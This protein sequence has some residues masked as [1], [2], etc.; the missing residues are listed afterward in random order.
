MNYSIEQANSSANCTSLHKISS[1]ISKAMFIITIIT[2]IITIIGILLNV[3]NAIVLLFKKSKLNESPYTYLTSLAFSDIAILANH[4]LNYFIRITNLFTK[5]FMY[6]FTLYY[7]I[8]FTNVALNCSMYFT[9]AVTVERFI[10]VHSPFKAVLI[11]RRSIARKVCLI[12][13]LF[14][15]IK[16]AYLPFTYEKS[17]CFDYGFEQKKS[18]TLD[19]F[20][21]LINMAIPYVIIFIINISLMCSLNRTH[22]YLTNTTKTTANTH[23]ESKSTKLSIRL[24]RS[25]FKRKTTNENNVEHENEEFYRHCYN[26]KEARNQKKLTISLI[27]ILCLLLVCHLPSFLLEETLIDKIF[28]DYKESYVAFKIQIIGNKISHL[29]TY[30]NCSAN[31]I[32]YCVS[33]KKFYN[34]LRELSKNILNKCL[35]RS[36]NRGLSISSGSYSNNKTSKLSI[37]SSALIKS[38]RK[39]SSEV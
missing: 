32:I 15:L 12:I 7:L 24:S 35:K 27:S 4:L 31:F 36:D 39:K 33:N 21:F 3:L 17:K 34:S 28:G 25:F 10:F 14:T 20:E 16:N 5:E 38:N 2:L 19:L 1:D 29:L 9:L 11:C 23:R 18:K 22:S 26:D 30:I 37:N 13:F 6:Y 8:P